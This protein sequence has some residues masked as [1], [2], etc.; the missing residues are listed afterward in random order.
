MGLGCESSIQHCYKP[1]E[2]DAC[3][4]KQ[5]GIQLRK[6]YLITQNA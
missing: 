6:N 4:E 1:I 2:L 3:F 5:K